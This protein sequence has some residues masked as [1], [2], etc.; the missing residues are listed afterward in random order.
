MSKAFTKEDEGGAPEAPPRAPSPLP[1]GVPNYWTAAGARAAMA[2]IAR[3]EAQA[4]ADPTAQALALALDGA[5]IVDP[6]EQPRDGRVV[7][8]AIVTIGDEDGRERRVQIVGVH[9][10]TLLRD[11]EAAM[12]RVSVLSPLARALLGARVGDVVVARAPRGD[13]ELEIIAIALPGA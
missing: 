12:A 8:G 9:E 5:M 10:A 13:E 11:A 1:P 2:E 3:L 4:P 6:A 7:L